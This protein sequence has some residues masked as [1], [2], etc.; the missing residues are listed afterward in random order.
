MPPELQKQIKLASRP[1]GK[2]EKKDFQYDEIPVS[3]PEDKQVLLKTVYLSVDPYMRGRMSAAK[4]Y[5]E[6]FK[7]GEPIEGGVVSKVVKSNSSLFTEGDFVIGMLPWQEYSIVNEK[8]VRKVDPSIAPLSSYLSILGMTGLTAYFGLL[9]IGKPKEGETVVISGAAGAVGSAAG[10]IAKIKGAYVVGIAGSDEKV[11]YLTGKLGFDKA[12]NYRKSGNI[13]EALKE[14]CPNGIDI[15]F[16]N[17]GGEIGDA[18]LSLLNKFARVPVCGAISAYN[19]TEADIGHRVQTN[20]IKSSA[21]MK[22][23]VVND[24][25]DRFKEGASQLGKWVSEGKLTYEE[26][27]TEGFENVPDAFLGLFDGSN[28]GK[29]LVKVS[30]EE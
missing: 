17:V 4:S 15:Y 29:Q 10:Q 19:N 6:P 5:V 30:E 7:V 23:Y 20:L 21:L 2:P 22:G 26:T 3:E 27:I 14:A 1:H 9:D 28:L 16:E 13:R 11:E 24:Y 25:A 12:I 8:E 18:A